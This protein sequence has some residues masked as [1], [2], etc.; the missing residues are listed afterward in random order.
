MP[1]P[2]IVFSVIAALCFLYTL[3]LYFRGRPKL[4]I[5]VCLGLAIVCCVVVSSFVLGWKWAPLVLISPFFFVGLSRPLVERTARTVLGYRTGIDDSDTEIDVLGRIAAGD[6]AE[7]VIGAIS[8]D[9]QKR[10]ERLDNLSRKPPIAAVLLRYDV[11]F[12]TFVEMFESLW[13]SAL[14]DLAWEIVSQ[15]DDLETLITMRSAGKNDREVWAHFRF[16]P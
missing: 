1:S 16:S 11:P 12:D 7:R 5:G 14:H 2:L 9:R 15:P 4:W 6:D 3:S 13:R 8:K 10:R